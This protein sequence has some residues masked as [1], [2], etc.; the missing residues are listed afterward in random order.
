MTTI[1][2]RGSIL[3]D[4]PP[5]ITVT[6]EYLAAVLRE[7]RIANGA[8]TRAEVTSASTEVELKEPAKAKK[9]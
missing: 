2:L 3:S 9:K 8:A 4:M 1:D 7:L 5:P 6:D